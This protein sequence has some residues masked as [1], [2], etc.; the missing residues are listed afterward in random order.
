MIGIG[1]CPAPWPYA[2]STN[3]LPRRPPGSMSTGATN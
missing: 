1:I 3:V 2:G